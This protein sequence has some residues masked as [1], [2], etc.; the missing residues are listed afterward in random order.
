MYLRFTDNS[1]FFF[2]LFFFGR[3]FLEMFQ[4]LKQLRLGHLIAIF[5]SEQIVNMQLVIHIE[6]RDLIEWKVDQ[7]SRHKVLNG[8][9]E[10]KSRKLYEHLTQTNNDDL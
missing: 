5:Y 4:W 7:V 6:E 8:I 2:F 1:T 10:F 9:Q 3:N